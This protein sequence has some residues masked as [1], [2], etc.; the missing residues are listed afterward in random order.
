MGNFCCSLAYKLPRPCKFILVKG[1]I[2]AS[3]CVKF[4]LVGWCPPPVG[5]I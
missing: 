3:R 5:A 4:G 1:F 2:G